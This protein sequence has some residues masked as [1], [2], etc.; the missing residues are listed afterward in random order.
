MK[1]RIKKTEI[2]NMLDLEEYSTD[3]NPNYN[4][5]NTTMDLIDIE[6]NNYNKNKNWNTLKFPSLEIPIPAIPGNIN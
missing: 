2:K 1:N 5:N 4:S 6:N 3:N